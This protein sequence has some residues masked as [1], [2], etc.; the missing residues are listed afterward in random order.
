MARRICILVRHGNYHQREETPSAHQPFPL[1]DEGHAQA[2]ASVPK[3]TSMINEQGWRLH[4]VL[5]SS[6]LLRAW[7][8]SRII[9]DGLD[10]Q[11]AIVE[12]DQLA[13][14]SVGSGANL[15]RAELE[16]VV[17]SDPRY[18]SLPDNWK[19]D[20]HFRL[21]FIGAESLLDAGKRVAAYITSVTTSLPTVDHDVAILFVG[22]G[23]SFR[24]AAHHL[25]V[26]PF[27]K[28]AQLSMYHASPI[29]IACGE[30]GEWQQEAGQWK[31]RSG[32]PSNL[33]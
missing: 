22:H 13:E 5:H 18:E 12:S 11:T 27:D 25:G 21:P 29:A 16:D 31:V 26:L 2:R 7:Q 24:H 30:N 9:A 6:S 33:D 10:C 4:P 15:N 23:G 1:N 32:V 8:T 20:S 28:V 3:I 19:S 17:A 14:R